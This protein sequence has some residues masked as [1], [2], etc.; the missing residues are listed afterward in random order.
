MSGPRGECDLAVVGAGILGLATAR[1][2]ARRHPQ[3]SLQVLEREGAIATHQTGHN[4]GVVHQGVYYKPGSLKAALCVAG[5]RE[6]YEYCDAR[7]IPI[8]RCGKL[9]VAT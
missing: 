9:I 3:L 8:E 5:A 1:E 6:L 2:L 7:E 4:S